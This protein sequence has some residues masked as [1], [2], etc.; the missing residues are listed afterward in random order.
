MPSDDT[1]SVE[2]TNHGGEPWWVVVFHAED[3][4]VVTTAVDAPTEEEATAQ[5]ERVL[6]QNEGSNLGGH[7]NTRGPFP[8]H[9]P[10]EER[11]IRPKMCGGCGL[12]RY[13]G[14]HAPTPPQTWWRLIEEQSDDDA[15]AWECIQ[16]R[17]LTRLPRREVSSP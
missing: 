6:A 13:C 9:V 4:A 14:N 10:T 7:H 15:R 12:K 2:R 3:G 1:Q 5:G 17:T 16:C 11:E 8:K